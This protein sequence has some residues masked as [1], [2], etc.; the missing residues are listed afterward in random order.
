MTSFASTFEDVKQRFDQLPLKKPIT[1][2]IQEPDTFRVNSSYEVKT[3]LALAKTFKLGDVVEGPHIGPIEHVGTRVKRSVVA[4]F[5]GDTICEGVAAP[6]WPDS[7]DRSLSAAIW[8]KNRDWEKL[9]FTM[10][11]DEILGLPD[12]RITRDI[13]VGYLSLKTDYP[14]CSSIIDQ[15]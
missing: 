1:N 5:D 15:K 10:C 9:R 3:F 7:Q 4:I 6:T 2:N 8:C 11:I 12:K 13:L 14:E